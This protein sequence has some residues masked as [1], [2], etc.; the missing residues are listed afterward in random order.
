MPILDSIPEAIEVIRNGGVII[1]VD[2]EDRENEGDF[3]TA[4]R[5]V[6]PEVINFMATHGRGLIC[7]PLIESRCDA[8]GLDLMVTTNNAAYETPFTVSVDLLGSGCTTGISA[9]DRSKTVMALVDPSTKP[10]DLGKPGH[11]FPLRAKAGGVLRRNGHTEAAIDF[12]R[13]AGFEPAGVIVEILN[14]D[15]TMARLPQL[16]ELAVKHD[17]KLVSIADLIAYR[18]ENETLIERTAEVQLNTAFGPFTAISYKQLTN[19]MEHLALFKGTWDDDSP[20]PVRVHAS[21]MIGDVFQVSDLGKGPQLHAAMAKIEE[22]GCGAIVFINKLRQ[23]GGFAEELKA[24]SQYHKEQKRLGVFHPFDSK[25]YGIGAQIVRDLG[26]RNINLLS[27]TP[28]KTGDIGYGLTISKHTP[29]S[30]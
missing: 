28:R 12:S 30:T 5:N 20:V 19:D 4:A 17:M 29:I 6:T 27:D 18:L 14:E 10:D 21:S 25:D 8:L 16:K 1:V 13:L 11:I 26:I 3:L 9:S 2:D 23:G 24:Y 15:G 22:V 7:A